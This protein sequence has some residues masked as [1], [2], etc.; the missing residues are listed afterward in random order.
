[1]ID[2]IKVVV[3]GYDHEFIV[4]NNDV[5]PLNI[6]RE[7]TRVCENKENLGFAKA[8]NKI[9]TIAKG[10]VLCLLNPDVY[11]PSEN[12]TSL[13]DGFTNSEVGIMAPQ[14][15]T[16]SGSVQPWSF[17]NEITPLEILRTNIIKNTHHDKPTRKEMVD[18]V[19]GAAFMIR[20][21]VFEKI[22][23]FDEKFFLYYEDVDL[24]RRVRQNGYTVEINPEVKITHEKGQSSSDQKRQKKH[25]FASQHHYLKKNYGTA[26]AQTMKV[27]RKVTH[28]V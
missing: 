12:F 24:C 17:G 20:K 5:R 2:D 4:G 3:S 1:M 25:Y 18:W 21:E 11:A 23:G 16:P 6:A 7:N 28:R 8:H 26:I 15:M 9:A 19:T 27:L 10:E 22:G 14:I 13:C